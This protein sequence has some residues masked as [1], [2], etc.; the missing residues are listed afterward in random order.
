[1]KNTITAQID[2]DFKGEHFSP[3]ATV[4]LDE[5]MEATGKAPNLHA[6][7][8][9][10]NQINLYSYEIE[11]MEVSPVVISHSEGMV[12]QFVSENNQL[13]VEGFEK[14][15]HKDNAM[16]GLQLIAQKHL[17]LDDLKQDKAIQQ[18]LLEAYQLGKDD[19][20]L[21]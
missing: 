2:F 21:V 19:K 17:G 14:Q 15:W 4:D 6:L 10:S 11:V 16:V 12:S 18:A 13:D 8:A 7:I 9:T 3:S 5:I 1:M 20:S